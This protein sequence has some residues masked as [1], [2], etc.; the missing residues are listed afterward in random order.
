MDMIIPPL[1][2]KIV[3]ESSPLKSKMLVRILTVA[4]AHAF[5]HALGEGSYEELTRLARDYAGSNYLSLYLDSL[6]CVIKLLFKVS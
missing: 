4:C 3:L 2:I 6:S 1:R 5:A